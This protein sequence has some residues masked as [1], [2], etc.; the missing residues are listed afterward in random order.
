MTHSWRVPLCILALVVVVTCL[1]QSV[2]V[3]V[4]AQRD[5]DN[6]VTGRYVAQVNVVGAAKARLVV[7]RLNVPKAYTVDANPAADQT[8][9]IDVLPGSDVYQLPANVD[10]G[11]PPVFFAELS[12][13]VADMYGLWVVALLKDEEKDPKHVC[14]IVFTSKG[15]ATA[16]PLAFG[17]GSVAVKDQALTVLAS[18]GTFSGAANPVFGDLNWSGSIEFND[19]LLMAEAWAIK[20]Q[21]VADFADLHPTT[22]PDTLAGKLSQGN[23]TI[24]FNDILALAWAWQKK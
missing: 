24:D 6:K 22:G 21:R 8:W 23:G 17:E 15:R 13:D 12:E 11:Q 3:K 5:A 18:Q 9:L 7:F 10:A 4:V 16:V 1:A 2:Q 14:N 19:V 20:S